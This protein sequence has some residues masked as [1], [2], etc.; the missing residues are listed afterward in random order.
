MTSAAYKHIVV[1]LFPQAAVVA[2]RDGHLV[3]QMVVDT[4]GRELFDF[5]QSQ[6]QQRLVLDFSEVEYLS[7][8]FLATL[9]KL[10][11]YLGAGKKGLK[12][13]GINADLLR[14]FKL[15]PKHSFEIYA[16]AREAL[17]SY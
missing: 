10:R 17:A 12:L 2:L 11:D 4:I 7:S 15:Y 3:D 8:T 6:M 16:T 13:S 1:E 5:V 14:L 9:F